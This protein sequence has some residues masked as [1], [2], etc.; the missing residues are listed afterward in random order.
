MY[1]RTFIGRQRRLRCRAGGEGSRVASRTI[2]VAGEVTTTPLCRI[3]LFGVSGLLTPHVVVD[4]SSGVPE[5]CLMRGL[6][7][8]TV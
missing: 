2:L 1:R 5:M 7:P 3:T 6:D 4:I 8:E